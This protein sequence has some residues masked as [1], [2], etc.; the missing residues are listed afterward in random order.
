MPERLPDTVRVL[1]LCTGNSARSQ[2]AEALLRADAVELDV[3]C[4]VH[5]AGTEPKGVNPLTIEVMREVDI[6]LSAAESKHLDRFV[7]EHW[8][9]L[10]TV[11]DNAREA[12]PVFPGAGHVLHWSFP[13]PA[14]V[15]GSHEE[16][17][18]VFRAVRDDIRATGVR[19]LRLLHS[20]RP[21][22]AR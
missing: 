12:C 15:E 1:F 8:D 11:C 14:A 16:R 22:R 19:F 20:R 21:L 7:D 9:Y 13:D 4:D 3:E 10:I 2:M 17:L 18:E 6:N 5:S